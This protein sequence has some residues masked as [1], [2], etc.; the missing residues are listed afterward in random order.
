[1]ACAPADLA[2]ATTTSVEGKWLRHAPW[3]HRQSALD[4]RMGHGRWGTGSGFP[5]LYLGQPRE[6]VI[7]EAYRHLVD[8]IEF[9]T[10]ADRRRFL[11]SIKPRALVAARVAVHNILDLRGASALGHASLTLQDLQSA[12]DDA[13]A[14]Q[15]C[16]RVA[17]IAHQLRNHGVLAPA[18]T[19]AGLTLALF[20]DLLP[21]GERPVRVRDDEAWLTLPTDPRSPGQ[22]HLR[23]VQD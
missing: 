21:P 5:V 4:G 9:E 2:L 8:P 22:S 19:G 6:S 10:P 1:M 12:T 18:A 17:Q 3:N 16:Q 7:I 11:E 15:R 14:Y 23:V 20:T 13:E